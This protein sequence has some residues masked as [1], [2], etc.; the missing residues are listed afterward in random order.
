MDDIYVYVIDFPS[1]CK[2]NEAVMKCADGYTIL[3]NAVLSREE[4]QK[5]Y[6]HALRHIKKGDFDRFDVQ[7]IEAEA[8]AG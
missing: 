6:K 5:A 8:H 4:Q 7:Q 1:C 3:I 2:A